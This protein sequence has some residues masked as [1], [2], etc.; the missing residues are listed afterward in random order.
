MRI[1][2]LR[3]RYAFNL[4][5]GGSVA[6][7]SGVINSLSKKHDLTVISNDHLAE[8]KT[9]IEIIPPVLV[10]FF[11]TAINSVLYNFRL[12]RKLRGRTTDQ[13]IV[14]Q[15]L[16]AFSFCGAFLSSKNKQRFILEYNGSEAWGLKYWNKQHKWLSPKGFFANLYKFG[17]EIPIATWVEKYNLKKAETVVVVSNELERLLVEQGVDQRKIVSYPNG[18]D[19]DKFRPDISGAEIRQK[20]NLS[21][22][23]IVI[24]FIGT[25]GQWHGVEILA[26]ALKQLLDNNSLSKPV[27]ALLIGDG[28]KMKEVQTI[29]KDHI[30]AGNVILTGTVPQPEAPKYLAACDIL[31]S[32]HKANSDGTNFFG[33]PTKLFEYMAMGKVIIA[34]DLDQIGEILSDRKN[35]VMVE[36]GNADKLATALHQTIEHWDSEEIQQLG[37]NARNEVLKKYTWDVHTSVFLE[38]NNPA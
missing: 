17:L 9:D 2:Y 25:F 24:G 23:E 12:I 10:R 36:P 1:L 21:Q 32:P 33:S 28:L 37:T 19:P 3:T 11:P 22:N 18:V 4:K 8:V 30:A 38:K 34:S 29:L 15:R 16:S 20:H 35:A 6:H 7:T 31:A 13:D 27:K 5:A 26:Q 14:Y